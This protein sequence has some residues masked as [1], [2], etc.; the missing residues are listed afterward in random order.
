METHSF[1]S[2][3]KIVYLLATLTCF[4]WGSS[5]PAIKGG[6]QLLQ[7]AQ[8][9]MAGK[10]VFAGWRCFLSG[11]LLECVAGFSGRKLFGLSAKGW[12]QVASLGCVQTAIMFV[13]FYLGLAHTTG[14]KSSVLNGTV[15]FFGVLL[16]HFLYQNDRL[17]L[18]KA[19]GCL[20][21]FGG[22][23]V[24]NLSG[25]SLDFNFTMIGEGAVV[26]SA[27]F[28]ASGMVLG[29]HISQHMDSAVMT[30]H[31][32]TIGGLVLL[33]IGYALG[34][35]IG[36]VSPN[37]LLVLGYLVLNS[38]AAYTLWS[39]LLKYNP[40]GIVS[41][42]NFLVPIFGALLSAL[43][44]GETVLEWKNLIALALVC[45]GIWLVT[46][47]KIQLTPTRVVVRP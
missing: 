38:A 1:F 15:S 24:I 28:M 16:A 43:F 21:G 39:I 26:I 13:F 36:V 42:F 11:A 6:F 10:L 33:A 47:R 2:N 31:Q 40:V 12:A 19:I 17:T 18:S 3:R 30:G 44:L 14:V 46:H 20:I 22:V 37:S 45:S 4:L 41:V 8:S 25:S 5:Y 32:L 29:K 35:S 7:I 34:G 27:F 23:L 9:D